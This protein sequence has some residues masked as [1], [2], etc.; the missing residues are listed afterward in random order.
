MKNYTFLQS[1]YFRKCYCQNLKLSMIKTDI[2]FE[3]DR[4]TVI[5]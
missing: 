2:I 3:D 5:L 4:L 1:L